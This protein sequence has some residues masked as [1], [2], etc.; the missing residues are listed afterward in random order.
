MRRL[1]TVPS[2]LDVEGLERDFQRHKTIGGQLRRRQMVPT[3]LTPS[4]PPAGARRGDGSTFDSAKYVAQH[5]GSV[6]ITQSREDAL[7]SSSLLSST[8]EQVL[9]GTGEM[10]D[11]S[12]G[13]IASMQDFRKQVISK[14][15]LAQQKGGNGNSNGSTMSGTGTMQNKKHNMSVEY[16]HNPEF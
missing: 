12:V 1:R 9:G 3:S 4:S 16:S 6:L 14:K 11:S 2:V 10:E 5:T 13:K 7:M 15:V 8:G